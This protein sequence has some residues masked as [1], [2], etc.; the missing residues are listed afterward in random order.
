MF[1]VIVLL[2]LTML[3]A[4]AAGA[5]L[6]RVGFPLP[7]ER[8][9]QSIDGLRGLLA[10]SVLSHHVYIWSN[11]SALGWTEPDWNLVRQLGTG[12][13]GLFFMI[14][15][16][17]FYRTILRLTPFTWAQMMV[18]R[19]FRIVPLL[20]VSFAV[21]VAIV[22][23]RTQPQFRLLP[24][25]VAAA[26]WISA[27]AEVPIFGYTGAGR[28]NAFVLWSLWQEWIFYVAMIPVLGLIAKC[29]HSAK[30]PSILLPIGL[31]AGGFA[32][33]ALVPT[34]FRNAGF[35]P[36][37]GAG[38]LAFELAQTR[39]S[40]ILRHWTAAVVAI[41]GLVVAVTW[42]PNPYGASFP[43]FAFF[44]ACVASGNSMGGVLR[45]AAARALG[46]CSFG[47]YL[48]HGIILSVAFEDLGVAPSM[49]TAPFAV[50]VA[51]ILSAA[52]YL[53]VEKPLDRQGRKLRRAM[54]GPASEPRHGGGASREA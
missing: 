30:A 12:A 3:T 52:L 42:T 21:I 25:V 37:F 18:G 1:D 7:P 26:Q 8:N 44:F 33:Q 34:L 54:G 29:L 5:A 36:L 35:W 11:F 49:A 17:L 32:V 6:A 45:L 48:L 43:C 4:L 40:A 22:M 20:T 51:I 38:M 46:E 14:T 50:I 24:F 2:F 53:T 16:F 41:A 13:V 27:H 23:F 28:I 15:G 39:V 9:Q 47:I 19:V 10:T 31:I